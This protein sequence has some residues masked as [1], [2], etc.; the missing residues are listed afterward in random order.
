MNLRMTFVTERSALT[1][2]CIDC[3]TVTVIPFADL[4]WAA[5]ASI[6]AG[7]AH[8]CIAP[9]APVPVPQQAEKDAEGRDRVRRWL[10]DAVEYDAGMVLPFIDMMEAYEEQM[11]DYPGAGLFSKRL[12]ATLPP[13]TAIRRE[14][15][16]GVYARRVYG[17][18]WR[19]AATRPRAARAGR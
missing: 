13:G 16:N 19:G 6:E 12:R 10:A 11:S 2:T 3:G 4:Q 8:S 18:R 17:V 15:I 7:S 14:M 5:P 1:T 9:V